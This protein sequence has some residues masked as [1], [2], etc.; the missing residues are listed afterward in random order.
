MTGIPFY[1]P[2][3]RD[4]ARGFVGAGDPWRT[5]GPACALGR[6]L[7]ENH[8]EFAQRHHLAAV[9]KASRKILRVQEAGCLGVTFG[10]EKQERRPIPAL[11]GLCDAV[12]KNKARDRKLSC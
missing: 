11:S 6:E 1:G 5:Q 3:L 4:R 9:L 2:R 10:P 12:E 8:V 7:R